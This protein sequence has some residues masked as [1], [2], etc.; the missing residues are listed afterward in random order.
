[1]ESGQSRDDNVDYFLRLAYAVTD[2]INAY[3]S[4]ATGFKASS[5]NLSRQSRP[6]PADFTAGNPV[7][8]PVT[9]QRL[10]STPS[11]PI[12]DAGL[13]EINLRP[14]GRLSQPEDADVIEL[15]I[16]GTF[17]TFAFTFTIFD[18]TIRNFQTNIFTEDGFVF[19]NAAEQST[20]GVEVDLAWSPVPGLLLRGAA[21][22]MD[23][24][25]DSYPNFGAGIDVSGQQPQGI[26]KVQFNLGATYGFA[27]GSLDAFVRTDWQHVGNSPFFDD[28]SL[29]ALVEEAGYSRE[30]N[31][32]NLSVGVRTANEIDLTLWSRNL[33][34]DQHIVLAVPALAQEGSIS[35]VPSQPRTF[36]VTVRKSF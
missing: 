10:L 1:V 16:R 22:F 36:G 31:I 14:G 20:F 23:P 13:S 28:P 34:N 30:Q 21:T 4:Y 29:Q 2:D 11:S 35:G 17:D 18:Q 27:I 25:Y 3:V 9:G 5:W 32:V 33:F 6:V 24:I 12:A 7:V 19:G 15:G 8:D 26:A